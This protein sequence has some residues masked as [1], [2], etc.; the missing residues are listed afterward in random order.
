MS[1]PGKDRRKPTGSHSYVEANSPLLLRV[2]RAE[3]H[4]HELVPMNL[5]RTLEFEERE[6]LAESDKS[7]FVSYNARG[8]ILS[9]TPLFFSKTVT[10]CP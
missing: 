9:E 5:E 6:F 3:R 10:V 2:R 7:L 4:R 8:K 1:N